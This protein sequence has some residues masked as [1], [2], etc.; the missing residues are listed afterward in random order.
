[1]TSTVHRLHVWLLT[2]AKRE[3][4]LMQ[5]CHRGSKHEKELRKMEDDSPEIRRGSRWWPLV[6]N[7]AV[8]RGCRQERP[9]QQAA[10]PP[11]VLSNADMS[12]GVV[13]RRR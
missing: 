11:E 5:I 1:M 6:H 12:E 4:K 7:V 13:C 8:N 2:A 10:R 3:E 9:R